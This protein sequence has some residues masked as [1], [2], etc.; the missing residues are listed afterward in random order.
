MSE[1]PNTNAALHIYARLTAGHDA[2]ARWSDQAHHHES[3]ARPGWLAIR[4]FAAVPAEGCGSYD[5]FD[6]LT[7]IELD[8]IDAAA[9]IADHS[10]TPT[11]MPTEIVGLRAARAVYEVLPG[12]AR[13]SLTAER[14]AA[15]LY[16]VTDFAPEDLT[17]FDDWCAR[18]SLPD[19]LRDAG[20]VGVVRSR[21]IDSPATTLARTTPGPRG[22]TQYEVFDV[23]QL[24]AVARRVCELDGSTLA[25]CA[26]FRQVFPESGAYTVASKS[27]LAT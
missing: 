5:G 21:W 9:L 1:R 14:G 8:S 2:L 24:D 27:N 19:A 17:V 18:A 22:L 4:R 6:L 25:R 16:A 10:Y 13:G 26:A 15:V 12:P 11:P 7:V 20:C 3:L 23:A